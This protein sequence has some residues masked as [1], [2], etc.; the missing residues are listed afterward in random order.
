MKKLIAAI[1]GM[2]VIS[3]PFARDFGG[4][5]GEPHHRPHYEMR[6]DA[7]PPRHRDAPPPRHRDHHG[8]VIA[9]A[10]IA[11]SVITAAAIILAD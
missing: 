8:H 6:H 7:P 3:A 4:P 5:H 11:G 2:A 10:I 1:L 9:D